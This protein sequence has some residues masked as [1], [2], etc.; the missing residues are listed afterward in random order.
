[1]KGRKLIV[2]CGLLMGG[3]LAGNA[4]AQQYVYPAKGQTQEQTDKD[5][6]DCFNWAKQ[7]TG[8]DPSQPT[9]VATTSPSSA[10]EG[11]VVKTAA[12]GAAVGAVAGAV[13]G[14]AGKGAAAG[15]AGGALV[16]GMKKRDAKKEAQQ[17]QQQAQ[18]AASAAKSSYDK[19][20]KACL[21]GKGYSVQ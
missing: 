13:A 10:G 3:L 9:Q 2:V 12:R 14:D 18:A 20:Y 17:Q 21:E 11:Q 5:K 7:Q 15:A 19:A 1:M 6:Y 16:G 4:F 8:Y